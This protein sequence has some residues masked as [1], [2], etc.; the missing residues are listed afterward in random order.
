MAD[1]FVV[2]FPSLQI[3]SVYTFTLL[4]CIELVPDAWLIVTHN[5]PWTDV[6]PCLSLNWETEQDPSAPFTFESA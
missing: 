1:H 6:G 4:L 3:L 5:G 2:T